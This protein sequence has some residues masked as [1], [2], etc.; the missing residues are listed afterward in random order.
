M[1][2]AH[3][4]LLT[5]PWLAGC[6]Q[7]EKLAVD[8]AP[9]AISPATDRTDT[10]GSDSQDPASQPGTLTAGE[11][12]DLR[13]WDFW[14]SVLQ[15][16]DWAGLPQAWQLYPAGRY[17]VTLTIPVGQP[18]AGAHVVLAGGSPAG[19]TE[20]VTDQQGRAELFPTLF[21]GGAAASLPM[22]VRYQGQAFG[23]A[24]LGATE[25]K[26]AR[27][28][29]SQPAPAAA[30]DLLFL[31]DA[32][33]SMGDEISYLQTELRDVITRTQAQVP[34][35]N[36]RLASV[37]YRDQGD[38]YLT[39]VQPFTTDVSQLET[40]VRDQRADGGGDFPE[41][42]NEA[43]AAALQQSWSQQARCR[44]LFLV[45][46]APPHPEALARIQSLTRQAAAQGIQLIPVAASGVDTSTEFLLRTLAQ[47]TNGTYIF[48]TDDSGIGN[49][50]LVPTVGAYQVEHLNDLLVRL[51]KERVAGGRDG[52]HVVPRKP[53]EM[54]RAYAE[55]PV[56]ASIAL[57]LTGSFA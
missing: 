19:I 14:L 23:V 49:P 2:K 48:L 22:Q 46:D 9:P 53:L 54:H 16:P 13:H 12:N 29:A 6:S 18:L 50:H 40:F 37:F 33:G 34:A 4:L 27:T 25:H 44:L 8:A 20:A 15:R 42:V 11:W 24:P 45:L 1:H 28:V 5:L 17:T 10:T 47:S 52:P 7:S 41:A 31:V 36:L 30:V 35:A 32:T 38:E 43:L 56:G 3:Y 21:Q 57:A 55:L 26:A 39:R 51:I